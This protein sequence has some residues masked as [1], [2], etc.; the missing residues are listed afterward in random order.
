M[1]GVPSGALV[2]SHCT[3]KAKHFK[4]RLVTSTPSPHPCVRAGRERPVLQRALGR[5]VAKVCECGTGPTLGWV[6]L[7]VLSPSTFQ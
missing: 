7:V 4:D 1:A 5:L 2:G 3:V 6:M